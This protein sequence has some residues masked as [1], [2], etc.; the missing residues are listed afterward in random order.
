MTVVEHES[1]D[2]L[3]VLLVDDD[4]ALLR[5]VSDI[6]E[7]HGHV[8][9]IATTATEAL[10]IAQESAPALA[11]L[12]LWLPDMAGMDLAARLRE[13]DELL[14][15]VVLTG[16]ASMETAVAALRGD[17]FDY[18]LKPVDVDQL[19][20]VVRIAGER[21]QRRHAE[22][23]LRA[24]EERYRRLFDQNP[25]PEW[26][27]DRETLRFL[28]VNDAAVRH[29]GYS[30]EEFLAMTIEAIRPPEEV[31]AMRQAAARP[32][33]G[34]PS[35]W[36]HRT[37]AGR[38]IDVDITSHDIELDGRVA[39]IVLAVD[40]TERLRAERTLAER[41]RQQAA[42]AAFGHQALAAEDQADLLDRATEVIATTLG[43]PFSSVLQR[44]SEGTDLLVRAG[45]GW[46]AARV[47]ESLVPIRSD[48]Q[49]GHTFMTGEIAVVSDFAMDAR[50]AGTRLVQ[51]HGIRSGITVPIPCGSQRWGVL[52]AHDVRPREFSEDHV[53]FL[54]TMAHI[55]GA[56]LERHRT[57]TTLRQSQRLEAV[58]Q[59]ASG[60]AHDFNNILTAIRSYSDFVLESV[61]DSAAREDV[62]EIRKAADRAA[63]LTRQ[64][65]AFSRRQML[66]PRVLNLNE[67]V[68]EFEGMLRRLLPEN[69]VF[70]T[71]LD[72]QLENVCADRGQIE[73]VVMNLVVNARDAMPDG[74]TIRVETDNV[75]LHVATAHKYAPVNVPAGRYARL[76]VSDTGHGMDKK[77]QA[78]IFEPFFTTKPQG[79]GTGLG[80]STVYGIV[81]QS[82]G[83]IW[84][85]S[86]VGRGTVFKVY[87]PSVGEQADAV[88]PAPKSGVRP[89]H[90]TVLL[91]EDEDAVRA[92]ARRVLTK[93][94]YRVIEA[95]SG[96]EALR[97]SREPSVTI[98][99][100]VSDIVMPELNGPDLVRE[101]RAQ[102]PSVKV[103]FM[104]GYTENT[105]LKASVLQHETAFIEK[106]FSLEGLT[107]KVREVLDA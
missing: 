82:N 68:A 35:T 71:T 47:G 89:G 93:A 3:R 54:E 105:I 29:Y 45:V 31:P 70:E 8:A 34:R 60:V 22:R 65:L 103:L 100:I 28:A 49:A 33:V 94:G 69:I 41:E 26:V 23:A 37:R 106:P 83:Y 32:A 11:I 2:A 58:G 25:Q 46:N 40:V 4:R 43:V 21:W 14:Q 16:H 38:I 80:L 9:V 59:L 20:Q 87:L 27:Y 57:E 79:A 13:R 101:V 61:G 56:S 10:R 73:Q 107:S 91:V 66:Q 76:V 51:D 92:I 95:R 12:D 50:F 44:H 53:R 15:T 42:V 81:K 86:E 97:I 64:L 39:R 84:C 72:P 1:P 75:N 90:E 24:S 74:G 18:L 63:E 17:S 52:G 19:L 102:Q 88:A 30:R 67:T 6:L 55:L 85:Y 77:T 62:I 48:R 98:D 96:T 36:R 78:R 7:L 104:S 99:L 5:T